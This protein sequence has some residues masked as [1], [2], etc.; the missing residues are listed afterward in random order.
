MNKP[1]A[2]GLSGQI[3]NAT[4]VPTLGTVALISNASKPN[5]RRPDADAAFRKSPPGSVWYSFIKKF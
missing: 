4:V 3:T 2:A 5:P 1:F